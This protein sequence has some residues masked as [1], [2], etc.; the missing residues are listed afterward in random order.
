MKKEVLVHGAMK[1]RCDKCG[2]S[3]W[4]FLEKGI[5]EF[6]K[7]HKPSPFCIMCRC[8]GTAMDVSGIVKI[9]DGGYKPLPVGEGYFAKKKRILIVGFRCFPSFLSRGWNSVWNRYGI[10]VFS[11]SVPHKTLDFQGFFSCFQGTEQMEQM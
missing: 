4:M 10:D 1:Y 8:G 7:N 5:E 11:I 2:R 9:P 6:G 3:W